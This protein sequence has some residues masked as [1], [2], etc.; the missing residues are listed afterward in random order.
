MSFLVNMVTILMMSAKLASPGLVEIKI[1][2]K[3]GYDVIIPDFDVT[4]KMLSSS[5]N[6]FVHAVLWQKFDNCSISLREVIIT[7]IS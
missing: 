2:Q 4:S 6:Y 5:S 7:S 3:E 1:F